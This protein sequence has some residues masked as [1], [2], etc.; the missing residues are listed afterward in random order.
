MS[1]PK[2]DMAASDQ[3]K[4]AALEALAASDTLTEAAQK[5]QISRKT[6]YNY[7]RHDYEFS[8]AYKS[9]Q[10]QAEIRAAEIMEEQGQQ[11]AGVI[12]ALMTDE[13]QPAA[14][15]LKAA[16]VMMDARTA[17]R[18]KVRDIA[19]LHVSANNPDLFNPRNH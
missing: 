13:K 17:Q 1:P 14:I 19:A 15:R 9:L 2:K 6:L 8:R 4:A 12:M 5:A 11:A 3:K 16:Q 18:A 7:I 10:E